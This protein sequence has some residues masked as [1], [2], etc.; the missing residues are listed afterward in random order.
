MWNDNGLTVMPT[1]LEWPGFQALYTLCI[2]CCVFP[3]TLGS[4]VMFLLILTL[5]TQ[6]FQLFLILIFRFGFRHD[7]GFMPI[8]A[9]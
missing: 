6:A 2:W 7:S 1:V 9:V 3:D 8:I 4:T 5:T